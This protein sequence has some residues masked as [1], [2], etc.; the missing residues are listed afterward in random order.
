MAVVVG[1][2]VFGLLGSVG[3]EWIAVTGTILA[4]VFAG[5]ITTSHWSADQT[6]Q[7]RTGIQILGLALTVI[8]AALV[9]W[10]N[11]PSHAR[12]PHYRG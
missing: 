11:R 7:F 9:G 3:Y 4:A 1:L 5:A 12:Q 10:G 2:A 8:A 6:A